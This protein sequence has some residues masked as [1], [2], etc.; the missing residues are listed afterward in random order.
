M[1]ILISRN[2]IHVQFRPVNTWSFDRPPTLQAAWNQMSDDVKLAVIR[3]ASPSS[4]D[5]SCLWWRSS[6]PFWPL[7]A[8]YEEVLGRTWAAFSDEETRT[9]V[10]FENSPGGLKHSP[11]IQSSSIIENAQSL[12]YGGSIL[13][14]G[15]L[16]LT[17]VQRSREPKQVA[18][19]Y[20]L[21]WYWPN[22]RHRKHGVVDIQKVKR[23]R[24][25]V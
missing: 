11:R 2:I 18:F 23:S 4:I 17:H 24:V 13:W 25:V 10:W 1:P 22:I 12:S 7:V 9:L 5:N 14:R 6:S 8:L 16:D 19:S 21:L 3:T 20:H 15:P